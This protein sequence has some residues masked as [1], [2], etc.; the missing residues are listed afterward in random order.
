MSSWGVRTW[1]LSESDESTGTGVKGSAVR[2]HIRLLWT[3]S[4][5]VLYPT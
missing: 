5:V 1:E 3:W 2:G 4:T